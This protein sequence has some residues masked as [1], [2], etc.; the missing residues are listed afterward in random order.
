MIHILPIRCTIEPVAGCCFVKKHHCRASV[1]TC[2]FLDFNQE[3]RGEKRS[4]LRRHGQKSQRP[5]SGFH[6]ATVPLWAGAD[7]VGAR[8][9]QPDQ[10][11]HCTWTRFH[12]N[13]SSALSS[14]S[15]STL[16]LFPFDPCFLLSWVVSPFSPPP[17]HFHWLQRGWN[18][19]VC[20][21]CQETA[22]SFGH[23]SG[24]TQNISHNSSDMGEQT[25]KA[26]SLLFSLP[27]PWESFC[28]TGRTLRCAWLSLPA[29]NLTNHPLQVNLVI[30]LS[31]IK[32]FDPLR[33]EALILPLS[34]MER[35][36]PLLQRWLKD[37]LSE[38]GRSINKQIALSFYYGEVPLEIGSV[39]E[40]FRSLRGNQFRLFHIFSP[41]PWG[42]LPLRPGGKPTKAKSCFGRKCSTCTGKS[43]ST[44]PLAR[45]KGGVVSYFIFFVIF[46]LLLLN[47]L[48]FIK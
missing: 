6:P 39:S 17:R 1:H 26:K 13:L 35:L 19:W 3:G 46:F 22:S 42:W 37:S 47:F 41:L 9:P 40:R 5:V 25:F 34:N 18:V 27:R 10:Q 4:S 8:S 11:E 48:M 36:Q 45:P 24:A 31:W 14:F 7:S 30:N 28:G 33:F 21:R 32:I 38:A 16:S 43:L 2:G 12:S 44:K 23:H 20:G 29:N 15:P